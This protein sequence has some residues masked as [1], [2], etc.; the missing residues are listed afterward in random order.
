MAVTTYLSYEINLGE[1][2][3][4]VDAHD[5]LRALA[6]AFETPYS[7]V[8][9]DFNSLLQSGGDVDSDTFIPK[10]CPSEVAVLAN[11]Y[12]FVR[13]LGERRPKCV[14]RHA[15]NFVYK[16]QHGFYCGLD[17]RNLLRDREVVL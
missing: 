15:E 8:L 6:K 1:Y 2:S 11:L 4:N 12:D 3:C 7:Y 10:C 17:T 14:V 16:H 5:V 13:L 9:A